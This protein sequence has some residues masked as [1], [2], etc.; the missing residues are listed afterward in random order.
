MLPVEV[1]LSLDIK[2]VTHMHFS[3]CLCVCILKTG[4]ILR[5]ADIKVPTEQ[6]TCD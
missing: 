6:Q 4:F 1:L 3:A 5:H 2:T